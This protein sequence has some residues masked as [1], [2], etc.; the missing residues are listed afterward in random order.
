MQTKFVL[1][2]GF[3]SSKG[4]FVDIMLCSTCCSKPMQFSQIV[5]SHRPESSHAEA[6][7]ILPESWSEEAILA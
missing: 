5:A 4:H 2:C 7:L 1:G 3:S 6:Q